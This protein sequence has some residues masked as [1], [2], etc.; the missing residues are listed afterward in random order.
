MEVWLHPTDQGAMAISPNNGTF[1]LDM[2]MPVTSFVLV[3]Y[4]VQGKK[5]CGVF[6]INIITK[7][8]FA[9]ESMTS[10]IQNLQ[11]MRYLEVMSDYA[12]YLGGKEDQKNPDAEAVVNHA[13]MAKFKECSQANQMT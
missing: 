5:R 9:C 6:Q 11:A 4:S 10:L 7:D 13:A 3:V 12:A 8:Y 2:S 1:Q